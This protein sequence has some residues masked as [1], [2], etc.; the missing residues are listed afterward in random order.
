MLSIVCSVRGEAI[1]VEA[2]AARVQRAD[3]RLAQVRRRP[4][5]HRS[6]ADRRVVCLRCPNALHEG[7][8]QHVLHGW[9]RVP[10]RWLQVGCDTRAVQ[11]KIVVV[12]VGCE[13][14]SCAV[15]RPVQI[16]LH[17]LLV[18]KRVQEGLISDRS[19]SR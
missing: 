14:V 17:G 2:A 11:L 16:L 18:L 15:R 5:K 1:E 3:R 6:E 7:A 9:V 13:S 10:R 12:C 8:G 19:C 4:A